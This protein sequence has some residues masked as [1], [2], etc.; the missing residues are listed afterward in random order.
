MIWSVDAVRP[1]MTMVDVPTRPREASQYETALRTTPIERRLQ[2]E[3]SAHNL[4]SPVTV[5]P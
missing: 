5:L 4:S 2:K 3:Q 1:T